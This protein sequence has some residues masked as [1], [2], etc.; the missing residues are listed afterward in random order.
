MQTSVYPVIGDKV[1]NP[2]DEVL[3]LVAY[4]SG[5]TTA[6]PVIELGNLVLRGATT[7]YTSQGIG[8]DG[9]STNSGEFKIPFHSILTGGA[10]VKKRTC[11]TPDKKKMRM[12]VLDSNA[13]AI[14]SGLIAFQ[15]EQVSTC[16][17]PKLYE[18][19]LPVTVAIDNCVGTAEQRAK[20]AVAFMNT[21]PYS[22]VVATA[23][24]YGT[25]WYIELEALTTAINFRICSYENVEAPTV[26][27]PY[28]KGGFFAK[29]VTSSFPTDIIGA[30][31]ADKCL[32]GLQ[33]FFEAWAVADG[34]NSTTSNPSQST[35]S[36][37]KQLRSITV[38][39]DSAVTNATNAYTAL[40]GLLNNSDQV[41]DRMPDT[42]SEDLIETSYTIVRVDAGD[43]G[44]LST[45][46]GVYA[47]TGKTS[48]TRS[49]YTNGK[50]VY[51]LKKTNTTAITPD[52]NGSNAD[53]VVYVGI[54][55]PSDVV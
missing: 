25:G 51:V 21:I 5:A 45:A 49:A 6:V 12:R 34:I 39:Y 29:F 43:A 19:I 36:Y 20:A 23:V 24:Q 32:P 1:P 42:V 14:N 35:N 7:P 52:A 33:I 27:A 17:A 28:T 54:V 4:Y 18:D 9:R 31:D 38:L 2:C 53:D 8:L 44:A 13:C 47:L 55:K 10:G 46:N 3:D 26:V 22:P 15:V 30:C 48:F 40:E 11:I 37:V 50:S 41:L 16:Q